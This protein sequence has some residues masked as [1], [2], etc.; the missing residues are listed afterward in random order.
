MKENEALYYKVWEDYNEALW[1]QKNHFKDVKIGNAQQLH[2]GWKVKFSFL[3][4]EKKIDF[5]HKQIR[6]EKR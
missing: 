5:G 6:N 2:L 4:M 3:E 1:D